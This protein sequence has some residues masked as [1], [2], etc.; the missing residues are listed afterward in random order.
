MWYG[1][2]MAF[3]LYPFCSMVKGAGQ[4]ILRYGFHK[5]TSLAAGC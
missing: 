2:G 3:G 5:Y 4:G 1:R